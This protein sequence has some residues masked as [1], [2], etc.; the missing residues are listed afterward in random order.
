[1]ELVLQNDA[2]L[3]LALFLLDAVTV[4][5]SVRMYMCDMPMLVLV[6][7][8]RERPF[9]AHDPWNSNFKPLKI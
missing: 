8:K 2:L 6:L 4:S 9:G 1:M 5:G 7:L 3:Q